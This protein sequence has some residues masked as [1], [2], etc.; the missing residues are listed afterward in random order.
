MALTS[1]RLRELFGEYMI[2]GEVH[3]LP[4]DMK[5][6]ILEEMGGSVIW[7]GV[8]EVSETTSIFGVCKGDDETFEVGHLWFDE[9]IKKAIEKYGEVFLRL[10]K[11]ALLDSEWMNGSLSIHN[12][13]DALTLLQAS[14]RANI[15][16]DSHSP[17]ELEIVQYVSINPNQEFRCFVI[18]NTLCA[19]IQRYTDIF[20][21][22][23]EKQ[24]T[25]IVTAIC[26][27]YD[28]MHQT[29]LNIE[30]YTFDVMV[31][32]DK[33]TLID[34]DELDE[35]HTKNT[36]EGFSTLDEIKEAKV[37]P[38]FLYV[39]E[40]NQVQPSVKLFQGIPQ[41]FFNDKV[42]ETFNKDPKKLDNMNID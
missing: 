9:L 35:Y 23:I 29:N 16:L 20:T 18:Q 5:T 12:S 26:S 33:A 36:L 42:I 37:K 8:E 28:N 10:N 2:P 22:S 32:G 41:E 17:N 40:Q 19:I 3:L 27:L 7:D 15:S 34:A 39:K 1:S 6:I 25:Q 13:R 30:N 4:D 24:K 21:S 14:E 31:K 11:V 38:V